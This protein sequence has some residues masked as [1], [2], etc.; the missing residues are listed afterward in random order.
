MILFSV[1]LLP[2]PGKLFFSGWSSQFGILTRLLKIRLFSKLIRN[3]I[4]SE[5]FVEIQSHSINPLVKIFL[6]RL[7][8]ARMVYPAGFLLQLGI[9]LYKKF[10]VLVILFHFRGLH[11]SLSYFSYMIFYAHLS[12]FFCK[13]KRDSPELAVFR[14]QWVSCGL[15]H[16]HCQY[17]I[18]WRENTE[19]VQD[20]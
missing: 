19:S 8:L 5:C 7:F 6:V 10:P 12:Y 16:Q 1:S 13:W 20:L 2:Y 4:C 15:G 11:L 3:L 9:K 18:M 14:W 17:C